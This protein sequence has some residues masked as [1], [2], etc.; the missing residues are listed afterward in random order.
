V[1]AEIVGWR[2]HDER[3]DR[4][5]KEFTSLLPI[6]SAITAL[7]GGLLTFALLSSYP[8]VTTY[9]TGV[10]GPTM[11]LFGLL[12]FA[13]VFTLYVY[14]YGWD[15]MKD[16]KGLHIWLG[17]LLNVIGTG[18]MAIPNSWATFMMSPQHEGQGLIDAGTM[19]F[20]GTV[21]QAVDNPLWMPLN[22]HR[23][24]GNVMFGGFVVGAYAAVRFLSS[25]DDASR[26]YYDWMGYVG[27]FI[28]IAAIIPLP[29]AGYYLGRE[30]YSFSAVMGNNM[31]GGQFSWP[32][33][34]QG[35]MVGL[36]F[37]FANFYLWN[38]MGRI[39]GA[40]RYTWMIKY[41]NVILVV[42]FAIWL[43][44]HNLPLSGEEQAILGGQYHPILQFFGLMAAKLA[45]INFIIIATF[46][47]FLLYR[48]A[49]KRG[50]VAFTSLPFGAK[51]T[52]V[53][54]ALIVLGLLGDYARRLASQSPAQV[55][56]VDPATMSAA[57]AAAKQALIDPLVTTLVVM[58]VAVVAAVALT[59]TNRGKLAQVLYVGLGTL[60]SV[61]F[62]G[63]Y[64]FVVMQDMNPLLRNI[65]V[66]QVL[67]VL[68]VLFLVTAIDVVLYR[69]AEA[70][71]GIAWGRM[72]PRSQY[73]L[74]ALAVTAV[75]TMGWMGAI[76]SGLREDWHIYG[77]L[78]DTSDWAQRPPID[79]MMFI[80]SGIV[81]AFLVLV[82]AVFWL[83]GLSKKPDLP[84]PLPPDATPGTLLAE[85]GGE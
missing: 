54:P 74:I 50:E 62:L 18:L 47:S 55:M 25:R 83:S 36:L 78:R 52:V 75:M 2:T 82:A 46:V 48:R 45:A 56:G 7:L 40:E 19:A 57:A 84:A 35:L 42:C 28:G 41:I 4:L 31:M 15:R 29:F 10:F 58:M 70:V 43:T 8:R 49:N 38:G 76:R 66:T 68:S 39:V 20:T 1:L 13:E 61:F 60:T 65:S 69:G 24:I 80:V 34:I 85:G 72:P 17:V 23:F 9:L 53:V 14:Y 5:A 12:F 59:W 33:I 30:I 27:N 67:I 32:F 79:E 81:L 63:P 11:G 71:G 51:M 3:Y 37:I 16:K 77:V 26:A 73:A 21:W 6:T 22:I 64:G 44:P